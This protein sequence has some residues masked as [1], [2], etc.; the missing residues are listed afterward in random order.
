MIVLCFNQRVP[1]FV[2]WG[3]LNFV[4][5]FEIR[6][7]RFAKHSDGNHRIFVKTG[8]FMFLVLSLTDKRIVVYTLNTIEFL[9]EAILLCNQRVLLDGDIIERSSLR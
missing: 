1:K 9:K 8:L 5:R 2:V 7:D 3:I 6:I 4:N